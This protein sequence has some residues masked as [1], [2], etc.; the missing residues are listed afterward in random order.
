MP[1]IRTVRRLLL[2]TTVATL[3]TAAPAQDVILSEVAAGDTGSWIELHN[4]G[5]AAVDLSTWSLYLT[6]ATPH[7]PNTYWWAFPPGT[8]VPAAGFL[9]V[10]WM[11]PIPAAPVP[12]EV[13]TGDTLQHFLFGLGGEALPE[14]HGSL[15]LLRTQR[16]ELMNTVAMFADWVTWGPGAPPREDLAEQAG[17]WVQG[18]AA[19]ALLPGGS[20]ARHPGSGLAGHPELQWFVDPTPTP[21]GDNTGAADVASI[22]TACAP[23]G[24]HLLGAPRLRADSLPLLGNGGFALVVDHTTGVLLEHCLIAFAAEPSPTGLRGLLPPAPGDADCAVWLDPG[25][26]FATRW[27]RTTMGGTAVPLPLDALPPALAGARF[28]AQALVFDFWSTAWPPYQGLSNALV[29]TLG[30]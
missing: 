10:R 28:T 23:V 6:T 18:H 30:G 1:N 20:L 21:L 2:A 4:R 26:A 16:N 14:A 24:H 17:V 3:H 7:Q 13:A 27:L 25:S 22:G 11:A 5:A 9:L 15:A 12:G 29:V 8:S 19:P